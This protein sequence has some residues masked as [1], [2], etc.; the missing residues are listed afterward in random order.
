[1]IRLQRIGLAAIAL[2]LLSGAASAQNP[3]G[4]SGQ[5]SP[6]QQQ[7]PSQPPASQPPASQ[8]P[9]AQPPATQ[10]PAAPQAQQPSAPQP[11]QQPGTP[12]MQIEDAATAAPVPSP[13]PAPGTPTQPKSQVVE[14][15]IA[16]VNNEVITTID[17]QHS[18]AT[19]MDDIRQS[20]SGCTD[21]QVQGEFDAKQPDILR[22]L[23]D[24]S[25]LSQRG[26]DMD[27]NV[28]TDVIK[29]LDQIRQENHIDSM[30]DLEAKIG[31]AGIDFEDY[32]NNI[33]TRLL[34][35][36]VIQ[37]EVGERIIIDHEEIAQYY[38]DHPD[39]FTRPEQV[40]LREIFINTD[41]KA[42]SE[43]PALRKK[44]DNMLERVHN[45]DDF[46]ELAKHF[47]D[48][49]TAAQGGELGTF[50]RGQLAKDIED[51]V[52]KMNRNDVTD[53]IETKTG[54]LILQ[55]EQH[56]SAGLQPLDTVE[57]EVSSKLYMQKMEPALRAYLKELRE[58]SYV[59]VKPGYTDTASVP[60]T[61][62]QEISPTP[63]TIKPKKG[64]RRFLLFG[65]RRSTTTSSS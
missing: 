43:I 1:M 32:K 13:A 7:S 54:F 30:E 36:Q 18:R 41:K 40:V 48:G 4:S 52:F 65:K 12:S 63:D 45:G 15:V 20:C 56:Y 50:Q 47:S 33:R 59:E 28:E 27:I 37:R 62:I 29:Q 17:L 55:V 46:G 58:D 19:V 6:P 2:V 34:T 31:A 3:P 24:Q 16:R 14:E 39:E 53:V 21:A 10:P 11:Q 42:A 61:G 57:E 25:L 9:A 51:K 38:K 23:I 5:G 26:K 60:S 44:A 8:P 35:Q 22:D 64:M 49:G